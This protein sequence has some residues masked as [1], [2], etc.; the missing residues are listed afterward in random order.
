MG[1][2]LDS[3]SI[4]THDMVISVYTTIKTTFWIS[5]VQPE[6]GVLEGLSSP[7]GDGHLLIPEGYHKD[8]YRHNWENRYNVQTAPGNNKIRN[9]HFKKFIWLEWV[10]HL[11]ITYVFII[12][13]KEFSYSLTK[14]FPQCN[15][16]H[17][18]RYFYNE[19]T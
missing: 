18:Y 11:F 1:K 13:F 3:N 16:T 17:I 14:L 15:K 5:W 10:K 7:R 6:E 9:A 8:L 12:S 4:L 2:Y 19:Y